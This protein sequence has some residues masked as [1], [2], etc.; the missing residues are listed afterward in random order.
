MRRIVGCCTWLK[1]SNVDPKVFR[2]AM[3]KQRT[4]MGFALVLRL[5]RG[6][7]QLSAYPPG[8]LAVLR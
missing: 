3:P 1:L 8:L 5:R 4:G 6:A 7:L 2:V